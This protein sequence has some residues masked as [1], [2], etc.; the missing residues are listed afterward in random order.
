MSWSLAVVSRVLCLV[1]KHLTVFQG[2]HGLVTAKTL[3]CDPESGFDRVTVFEKA[4]ELGGVWSTSQI[5]DGL[6][7]NSPLLTYEIPDFPYP[8]AVRRSGQHATA[9]EVNSYLRAY[10]QYF[11]V[12]KVIRFRHK[13]ERIEWSR[14][15]RGWKVMGTNANGGFLECFSHVVVC[16]G[17]YHNPRWPLIEDNG[18][19]GKT[20]HSSQIGQE[21]VRVHLAASNKIVIVGAGKSAIDLATLLA[22]GKWAIPGDTSPDV[23]LVYRRPHWLSPRR[24]VRTLVPFE[25]LLFSRFVVCSACHSELQIL[26][27]S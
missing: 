25:R 16:T 6:C 4:W 9:Q 7:T 18:F 17:L 14:E 15:A 23:Y 22:Q 10:A 8:D 3:L 26:I 19:T 21:A 27:Q 20:Y 2:L 5:Y 11:G 1:E 12:T 24:I 13:V